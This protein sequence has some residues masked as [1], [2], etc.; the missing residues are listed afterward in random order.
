M[1]SISSQVIFKISQNFVINVVECM[2]LTHYRF[3]F[4][5]FRFFEHA[6]ITSH[7]CVYTRIV[8]KRQISTRLSG[9]T[10]NGQLLSLFGK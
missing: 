8:K 7:I 6:Y 10:Q 9:A 5:R 1:L 2:S 4:C 3:F